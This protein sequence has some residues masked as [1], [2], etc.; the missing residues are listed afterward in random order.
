MLVA[1]EGGCD[2]RRVALEVMEEDIEDDIEDAMEDGM[3]ARMRSAEKA[4][5]LIALNVTGASL[6]SHSG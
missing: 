2:M 6:E 1:G 4:I 5:E 3:I